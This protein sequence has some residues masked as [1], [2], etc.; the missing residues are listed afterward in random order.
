MAGLGPGHARETGSVRRSRRA[1]VEAAR[2]WLTAAGVL[3]S[4]WV[5]EL[6]I[7]AADED[8]AWPPI[9]EYQPAEAL[10]ARGAEAGVPFGGITLADSPGLPHADDR[11]V[12]FVVLDERVAQT[13]WLVQLAGPVRT[14]STTGEGR[15]R[16]TLLY[17][18]DGR[19]I[20]FPHR[21]ETYTILSIGPHRPGDAADRV[22]VRS[23]EVGM[24][25]AFLDERFDRAAGF[26]LRTGRARRDGALRPDEWFTVLPHPPVP[27]DAAARER[28][29]VAAGLTDADERAIA[30]TV[31]SLNEFA[32][33]ISRTP[34]LR[35]VLFSVVEKPSVWSLLANLGRIETDFRFRSGEVV[36]SG[37]P[38]LGFAGIG[39]CYVVPFTFSINGKAALEC[40]MLVAEPRPP[41]RLC[42]GIVAIVAEVP[43]RSDVRL[44][45]RVLAARPGVAPARVP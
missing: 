3:V 34:G 10:G 13:Q 45:V 30:A 23:L 8:A 7:H 17:G 43:G 20:R 26:M 31:P 16:E 1:R 9:H 19:A 36:P 28:F 39:P 35:E 22:P 44:I 40:T 5:V 37:E 25:A 33:V 41:L 14:A 38:P 18:M 27:P 29:V 15:I 4:T 11:V 12:L 21:R 24:N 42:G 32:R 2:G 6:P